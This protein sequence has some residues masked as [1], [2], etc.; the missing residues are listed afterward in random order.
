M[1]RSSDVVALPANELVLLH[2]LCVVGEHRYLVQYLN[3]DRGAGAVVVVPR[4]KLRLS[5]KDGK[6][7]VEVRGEAVPGQHNVER[8][9]RS[10][11]CFRLSGTPFGT[12]TPEESFLPEE[13]AVQLCLEKG[14]LSVS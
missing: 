6:S 8:A 13:S 7:E 1:G 4:F 14:R 5:S 11:K 2:S 10:G 9:L 12:N 3:D